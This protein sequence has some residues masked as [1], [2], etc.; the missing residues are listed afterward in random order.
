MGTVLIGGWFEGLRAQD[1]VAG[2]RW[3]LGR[4]RGILVE[5]WGLRDVDPADRE[6]PRRVELGER[7]VRDLRREN[8][9]DPHDREDWVVH[10]ALSAGPGRPFLELLIG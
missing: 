1:L 8:G 2:A 9:G 5:G 10:K 7:V 6:L 4:R 3:C